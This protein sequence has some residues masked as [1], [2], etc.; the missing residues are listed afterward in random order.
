M[1]FIVLF[2]ACCLA[3]PA[4]AQNAP[5]SADMDLSV[6]N[7]QRDFLLQDE[8][9]KAFHLKD[10][11]NQIILLFFG[12]TACPDEC[13]LT[14]SKLARVYSLLGEAR[15]S[16]VLTLFVT[17]DPGRDTPAKLKEYLRYF[18]INAVGLTGSKKEIDAVADL[19]KAMYTKV[20]TNAMAMPEM[21]DHSDY[22]YLIDGQGR[23]SHL[24]HLDDKAQDMARIIQS[25]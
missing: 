3:W 19:Y 12:Y 9:G 24:F 23:T 15:R 11:R 20:K 16:K 17:V 4:A 25:Y 2:I 21:F 8:D 14:L 5:S 22:I 13:P 7:P 1:K 18:K 6:L 10:H